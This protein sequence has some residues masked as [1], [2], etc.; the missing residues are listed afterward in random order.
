ML[1]IIW[2][3]FGFKYF[4]ARCNYSFSFEDIILLICGGISIILGL[5]IYINVY[6]IFFGKLNVTK[7]SLFG[8]IKYLFESLLLNYSFAIFDID[9][10]NTLRTNIN[11]IPNQ[12]VYLRYLYFLLYYLFIGINNLPLICNY[13]IK[14]RFI[15]LPLVLF[16]SP[17]SLCCFTLFLT[18]FR[19]NLSTSF[20]FILNILC[21]SFL[22]IN[23]IYEY[24]ILK[25]FSIEHYFTIILTLLNIFLY[26]GLYNYLI[27]FGINRIENKAIMNCE[28]SLF[29]KKESKGDGGVQGF[30]GRVFKCDKYGFIADVFLIIDSKNCLLNDDKTKNITL[31]SKHINLI[32]PASKN[33]IY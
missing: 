33:S 11:Q 23:T 20:Y 5:M 22:L 1:A 27:I 14:K 25:I 4:M 28:F 15:D 26:H 32:Y 29:I 2:T 16:P 30:L 31:D 9:Q 21:Y 6:D 13:L 18:L 8:N 7:R 12:N 10:L 3:I 19:N 17:N 24:S